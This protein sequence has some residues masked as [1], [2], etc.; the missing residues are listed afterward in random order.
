[1]LVQ[2]YAVQAEEVCTGR[3]ATAPHC[4]QLP[5][6]LQVVGLFLHTYNPQSGTNWTAGHQL[7]DGRCQLQCATDFMLGD[8]QVEQSTDKRC[9]QG[10][11][12]SSLATAPHC[13]QLPPYLHV[14]LLIFECM[15][16]TEGDRMDGGTSCMEGF[17]NC[18]ALKRFHWL[19]WL[20]SKA[21]VE[22]SR[23]K[24]CAQG[25]TSSSPAIASHSKPRQGQ[26]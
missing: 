11:T 12:T 20:K 1:M 17:T 5:P 3:L 13:K 26:L 14:T 25:A 4:K 19:N 10:A 8:A 7:H 15:Q 23:E 21:E 9:A 16:H 22:L 24:R 18:S 2:C 6:Y